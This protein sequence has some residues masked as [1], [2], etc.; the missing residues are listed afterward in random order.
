MA[1]IVRPTS[2]RRRS[3]TPAVRRPG[4]HRPL[5]RQCLA[6]A[7]HRFHRTTRRQP[8][9]HTPLSA[10]VTGGRCQPAVRRAGSPRT[11]LSASV[12]EPLGTA[13]RRPPSCWEGVV[14]SAFLRIRRGGARAIVNARPGAARRLQ[15]RNARSLPRVSR[16]PDL[17]P[18]RSVGSAPVC[19]PSGAVYSAAG[20]APRRAIRRGGQGRLLQARSED[21]G[22]RWCGA[23]HL[24]LR[25]ARHHAPL[26]GADLA[27][28][29]LGRSIR[30]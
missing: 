11:K 30:R 17:R 1:R 9:Q 27:H 20:A 19:H 26:S 3:T 15:P 22:A 8:G 29:V 14:V 10:G 25:P 18:C 4:T 6:H 28:P 21:Q 7:L 23:L 2:T 13:T 12:H 24:D 5:R 16:S